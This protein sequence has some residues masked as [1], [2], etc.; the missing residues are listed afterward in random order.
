[1]HMQ[2]LLRTS[3]ADKARA[4]RL[5]RIFANSLKT[6]ELKTHVIYSA[7][8][9]FPCVQ[10]ISWNDSVTGIKSTTQAVRVQHKYWLVYNL[11][12][13][14]NKQWCGRKPSVSGQDRSETKKIGLGLGLAHCGLA[15]CIGIAGFVLCCETQSCHA[16]HHNDLG[17][18]QLKYYS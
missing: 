12:S 14:R 4:Y 13:Y 8:V 3:N 7:H 15:H 10:S 6:S 1:M 11:I 5:F 2:L 17:A 18:F 16:R 9:L